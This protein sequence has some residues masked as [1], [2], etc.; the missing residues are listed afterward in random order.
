M[1]SNVVK[2]FIVGGYEYA[3]KNIVCGKDN[4]SRCPHG[5]Y[6]YVTMHL[7]NGKKV[8]KYIGKSLPEGVD[9]P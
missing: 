6:W 7:R 5:P 8:Q 2:K 1:A 4:C 9:E 3:L